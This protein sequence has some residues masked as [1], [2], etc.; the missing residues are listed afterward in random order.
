ML[1]NILISLSSALVLTTLVACQGGSPAAP[2]APVGAAAIENA[3]T[4]PAGVE[5][6]D[7]AL[8]VSV[9]KYPNSTCPIM[10]KAISDRLYVDTDMGRIYICCKGCGE[11][12]LEDLETA[13]KT[14]YPVVEKLALETCPLT[15]ETIEAGGATVVLQGYEIPLCCDGCGKQARENA[16]I[17]L[18]KALD[19]SLVDLRNEVCPITGDAVANNAFAVVSGHIIRLSSPA[20]VADVEA[21][22]AKALERAKANGTDAGRAGA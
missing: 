3:G 16:Q 14:A 5:T 1:R 22:P 21:A 20:C 17:V 19:P 10:G 18:A 13:H 2:S 7:A 11:P 6:V 15:G 4:T 9:P 12:I 8:D